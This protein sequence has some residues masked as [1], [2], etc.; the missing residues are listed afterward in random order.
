MRTPACME[1]AAS[2]PLLEPR[3]LTVY[4]ASHSLQPMMAWQRSP[5]PPGDRRVNGNQANGFDR[6]RAYRISVNA[7][8]PTVA[9]NGD[10]HPA[11]LPGGVTP[12][13]DCD[14][15]EADRAG[16]RGASSGLREAVG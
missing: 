12:R 11:H 7:N 2:S 10:P 3:R 6:S 15:P 1:G 8:M 13:G 14:V 9:W 5:G 4:R 16:G